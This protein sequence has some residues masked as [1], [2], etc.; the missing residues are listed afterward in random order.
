MNSRVAGQTML[1]NKQKVHPKIQAIKTRYTSRLHSGLCRIACM[2]LV[3][4]RVSSVRVLPGF[5]R[6]ACA[7][8]CSACSACSACSGACSAWLPTRNGREEKRPTNSSANP[9]QERNHSPGSSARGRHRRKPCSGLQTGGPP[10][11][12]VHRRWKIIK[13][14]VAQVWGERQPRSRPKHRLEINFHSS[15]PVY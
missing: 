1:Q 15:L 13:F 7:L 12:C 6:T 8:P 3:A 14:K 4:G 11:G 10:T 9:N 5:D 2:C